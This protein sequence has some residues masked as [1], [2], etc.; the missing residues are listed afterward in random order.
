[1]NGMEILNEVVRMP[2]K[3]FGM[4]TI[5]VLVCIV[6]LVFAGMCIYA[7][8]DTVTECYLDR[9]ARIAIAIFAVF[10]IGIGIGCYCLVRSIINEADN[11]ETI[12]YAT[13]DDTVPWLEVNKKYE[14]IQQDGKIYQLRLRE[15]GEN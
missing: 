9:Q 3:S 1:M 13:I 8:W 4:I 6:G 5:Y 10:V 2:E 14:L 7:I 11:R 15:D 12:V